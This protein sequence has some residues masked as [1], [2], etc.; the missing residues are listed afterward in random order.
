MS[1]Y[2]V[3][4]DSLFL[5]KDHFIPNIG[6]SAIG[7][8]S[9]PPAPGLSGLLGASYS[10]STKTS[11]NVSASLP[12]RRGPSGPTGT[13]DLSMSLLGTVATFA[14]PITLANSPKVV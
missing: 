8:N 6:G 3:R 5:L 2:W 14:P 4:S 7:F 1:I 13:D 11:G 9:L 10:P 12:R